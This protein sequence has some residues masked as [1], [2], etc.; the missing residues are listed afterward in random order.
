MKIVRRR[1]GD[2]FGDAGDAFEFLP[3]SGI[4]ALG[5]HL[6]G[7]VTVTQ[8]VLGRRRDQE[9]DRLEE[10]VLRLLLASPRDVVG[11]RL[12]SRFQEA[13]IV[14]D[15]VALPLVGLIDAENLGGDRV[16]RLLRELGVDEILHRT[17]FPVGIEFA[18]VDRLVALGNDELVLRTRVEAVEFLQDPVR[19]HFRRDDPGAGLDRSVAGDQ[20]I[21]ANRDGDLAQHVRGGLGP[22]QGH[23]L[24]FSQLV[25]FGVQQGTLKRDFTR[26]AKER[27]LEPGNAVGVILVHANCPFDLVKGDVLHQRLPI[28]TERIWLGG[29]AR[30]ARVLRNVFVPPGDAASVHTNSRLRFW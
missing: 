23:R 25:A 8:D 16:L 3:A 9:G 5:G 26:P 12:Q 19:V 1:E 2:F 29:D 20:L 30:G 18:P 10:D 6:G 27:G 15:D 22:A 13:R 28:N 7:Q 17:P 4:A 14:D 21:F 24:A 11:Q